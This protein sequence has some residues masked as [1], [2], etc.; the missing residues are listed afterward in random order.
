[1]SKSAGEGERIAA[2]GYYPQ[3]QVSANIILEALQENDVE[4]IKIADPEAGEVDD[5]QIARNARIDAY[6]IKWNQYRGSITF[7]GLVTSSNDSKPLIKQ[8]A[9]G[10]ATLQKKHPS[11]RVIV[12]LLTSSIPSTSPGAKLPKHNTP[13]SPYHF[14]AFIDQSWEVEK[15]YPNDNIKESNWKPVWDKLRQVSELSEDEFLQFINDCSL[16]F[17]FPDPIKS[18]DHNK[19]ANFIFEIAG[20]SER[21]VKVDQKELL[22]RLNWENRY[23][24]RSKHEF[25]VPK[26]YRPIKGSV[27][28]LVNRIDNFSGGYIAL[29]GGPGSGK[30]TLLTRT[31]RKLPHRLVRYYAYVPDAQDPTVIRG[32]SKNFL[33]DVTLRLSKAGFSLTRSN[34]K[35]RIS[36]LNLLHKQLQEL[37]NDFNETGR[38]TIILIDGLDHISREQKPQRSLLSDLPNPNAIPDGVYFVIGSQSIELKDIPVQVRKNINKEERLIKID[39]LKP[40]DV[41][42]IVSSLLGLSISH[43]Q[44]KEIYKLSSGHPLA[45]IYI[46]KRLTFA[47]SNEELEKFISNATPYNEDIDNYY[48]SH[49]DKIKEDESLINI[50][51]LFSRVRGSINMKWVREWIDTN[52]A[53]KIRK[54]FGPYFNVDAVDR[55]YFFHNSFRLF[56]QEQTAQPILE[57]SKE[58]REEFFHRKLSDLYLK[59]KLQIRHEALFHLYNAGEYNDLID[60]ASNDWFKR[61]ISELRPLDAIQGDIHLAIK[62]ASKVKDSLSLVRFTLLSSGIEQ[63]ASIVNEKLISEK[64]LKI[65]DITNAIEHI[66]DGDSLRISEVEA[67]KLSCKLYDLDLKSESNRL[68]ELSEPYELLSGFVEPDDTHYQD[69][70]DILVHWTKAAILFR[71]PSDILKSI[72][73]IV[74]DS[75]FNLGNKNGLTANLKQ[76][77]RIKA[78]ESYANRGKWDEWNL[79]IKEIRTNKPSGL[80]TAYL[81]S[82]YVIKKD[83]KKRIL[84]IIDDLLHEYDH[85]PSH[86][87]NIQLIQDKIDIAELLYFVKK[88]PDLAGEWIQD[89]NGIPINTQLRL[90]NSE[91]DTTNLR[92]HFYKMKF[93]LGDQRSP[94]KIVEEDSRLTNWGTHTTEVERNAYQSLS[95]IMTSLAFQYKQAHF[96]SPL[97]SSYFI[98]ENKWILNFVDSLFDVPMDLR[99]RMS[100][101]SETVIRLLVH[102]AF[103]Q[104]P[105]VVKTLF[106]YLSD[107]WEKDFWS[108]SN[109]RLAIKGLSEMGMEDL[110]NKLMDQISN[111]ASEA[112]NPWDRANE[113]WEKANTWLELRNKVKAKQ[114]LTYMFE[115]SRGLLDDHDHQSIVWVKWMGKMNNVDPENSADRIFYMFQRLASV[116]DYASGTIDATEELLVEA[117]RWEPEKSLLLLFKLMQERIL[118]YSS[119]V[120]TFLKAALEDGKPQLN[121]ILQCI[122]RILV[123]LCKEN[124]SDLIELL[125]KQI[126]RE[127]SNDET[128]IASQFLVERIKAEALSSNRNALLNGISKALTELEIDPIKVGIH[129]SKIVIDTSNSSKDEVIKT[130]DGRNISLEGALEIVDSPLSL[131]KLIELED[132]EKTGYFNWRKLGEKAINHAKNKEDVEV[133]ADLF[134]KFFDRYNHTLLFAHLSKKAVK[135][136]EYHL[137][138][139]LADKAL[140]KSDPVGWDKWM[141]GGSRIESLKALKELNP[142][143]AHQKAIELFGND[144]GNSRVST[145]RLVNHFDSFIDLLFLE[146]PTADIWKLVQDYLD[147]LYSS[148]KLEKFSEFREE[149][150]ENNS[151]EA[152]KKH[153]LLP[154]QGS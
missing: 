64:L 8:L 72:N 112:K 150:F 73:N 144:V 41:Q 118:R 107:L 113:H 54:L 27:S 108:I 22:K 51:G 77:L 16:D 110:A 9:E 38:K 74:A 109:R 104:S 24:F 121:L 34:E 151:S 52:D 75:R 125:I 62:A 19:L 141:D 133:L 138:E 99:F 93:L 23:E 47:R 87:N 57:E 5:L 124:I 122:S 70:N 117:Y 67:L 152:R 100:K 94:S 82:I 145:Q 147:D 111:V 127:Y 91:V 92:F 20:S 60:F 119:S 55:W 129:E 17:N 53:G 25:E 81:N 78:A 71:E 29:I 33:H 48:W 123:P 101:E 63:R 66:R 13:P 85:I 142:H 15:N 76:Y 139:I 28:R 102:T 135:L 26:F 59:S 97:S 11:R 79:F 49:W 4:W 35:D 96:G 128:I 137:A 83:Q 37:G 40:S 103:K 21:K 86:D 114:E 56:L 95:L 50:L 136:N 126:G 106:D 14:S 3:Y 31:L 116:S 44:H 88:S 2:S 65:G 130:K 68:F 84:Q 58:E 61:Q 10:W 30:S 134:D 154:C 12:H 153:Q 89:I 42:E 131:K 18:E 45:L 120:H 149:F 115:R 80:F 7:N 140:D 32:E 146:V 90:E 43:E 132:S 6:Q 148:I 39:R 69:T 46:T 36:L 98:R 105:E 143:K 1:M